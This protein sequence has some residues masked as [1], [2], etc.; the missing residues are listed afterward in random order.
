[1]MDSNPAA[2]SAAAMSGFM[3][4]ERRP[5][6]VITTMID[7]DGTAEQSAKLNRSAW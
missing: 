1:M 7:S 6:S 2:T 5:I 3:V 4:F